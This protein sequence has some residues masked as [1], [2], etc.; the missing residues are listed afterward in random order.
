MAAIAPSVVASA[1]TATNSG[2]MM[3]PALSGG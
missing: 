1:A 2:V 3:P